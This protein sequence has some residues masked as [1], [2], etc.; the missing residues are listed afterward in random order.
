MI[1]KADRMEI[2]IFPT[3]TPVA[4]MKLFSSMVETGAAEPFC[5]PAVS[6]WA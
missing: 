1:A 4:M 2:A 3:A 5:D 6:T